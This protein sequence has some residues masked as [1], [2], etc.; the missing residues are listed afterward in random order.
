A[1]IY[2]V[3]AI[4]YRDYALRARGIELVTRANARVLG[5]LLWFLAVYYSGLGRALAARLPRAPAR[6]SPTLVGGMVPPL[7]LWGLVCSGIALHDGD[8]GAEEPLLRQFPI[9]MLLSGILLIVTGRQPD[10]PRPAWTAAGLAVAAG[11]VAIWMFNAKRSH[12]M[13]GIL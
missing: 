5:S 12:S 13:I 3:Q 1:Q 9:F 7:F 2:V 10:R 6:W 8:V 4:S 11:Y